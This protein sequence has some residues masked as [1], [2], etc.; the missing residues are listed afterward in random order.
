MVYVIIYVKFV[1]TQDNYIYIYLWV[2]IYEVNASLIWAERIHNC[3]I[4]VAAGAGGRE[5]GH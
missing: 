3:R 1:S 4:V 2:R 5:S